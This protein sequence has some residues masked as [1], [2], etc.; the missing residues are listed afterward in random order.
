MKLSRKIISL[1]LFAF[2]LSVLLMTAISKTFLINH[3]VKLEVNNAHSGVSRIV[4]YI[5]SDISEMD[6]LA[7]AYGQWNDT[8]NFVKSYNSKYLNDNFSNINSFNKL[9]TNFIIISDLNGKILF[10]K[11][12]NCTNEQQLSDY[13]ISALTMRLSAIKKYNN[14]NSISGIYMTYTGPLMLVCQPISDSNDST[15]ENG[16]FILAKY[17]DKSEVDLISSVI[18][19]NFTIHNYVAADY[20]NTVADSSESVYIDNRNPDTISGYGIVN[21]IFDSP[22]LSVE[23][24]LPKDILI[25]ADSNMH[26]LIIIMAAI[27]ILFVL[28]VLKFVD[29][30]VLKRISKIKN[31]INVMNYT[32]DLSLRLE[33]N[34]NDEISELSHKF[35]KMIDQ[36]Q[37]SNENL[38]KSER[39]YYSLF[40]NMMSC[41][42]YGKVILNEADQFSDFIILEV[43]N[44]WAYIFD[45]TKDDLINKPGMQILPNELKSHPKLAEMITDV[46]LNGNTSIADVF[47]FERYGT[48]FH[49]TMYSTEKYHFVMMLTDI[50]DKQNAEKKIMN[51]AY[52]DELTDLPNRKKLLEEIQ[53]V[54]E[55]SSEKSEKFALLFIDLDNFKGIN[56]SL[57]HE[58]GDFVLEKT[59]LRLKQLVDDSITVGR[60]GGDEFIIILRHINHISQAEA[61]ANKLYSLIKPV[62]NYKGSELYIGASIGISIYPEDGLTLSQLLRNAD[63]AM[64]AAKRNGGYC[65]ELYS[66]GMND[67][68]LTELIMEGNLRKALQ[69]NEIIVYYQPIV[70]LKTMKTIGAEALTRWKQNDILVPPSQ[71]IPLAKNIGVIVDIDNWVLRTACV[72]CKAWQNNIISGEFHISVNTSYKQIKEPNFIKTVVMAYEDAGLDSKYLK[73]EITE[74]EAM[75]DVELIIDV[76]KKLNARGV[77]ADLDDFG[78]GYSSLSYVNRLPINILKIDRSLINSIDKNPRSVEIVRTIMV[79]CHSLGIRVLAEGVER[80]SQLELLRQFDCDLIQGFII[81]KPVPAEIFEKEFITKTMGW[82]I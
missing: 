20:K 45:M 2:V 41:F 74:D 73:L 62:I 43:N 70:D 55:E 26:F 68:A 54:L 78:T 8:Y 82:N 49:L 24:S 58:V 65:Y 37:S 11:T 66:R 48:W 75:E 6:A 56:D 52:V 3:F 59:A 12:S 23:L 4:K 77:S 7:T 35:N 72:Q 69:N 80:E 81:S 31:T 44:S 61:L 30:I 21:D 13:D 9:N 15:P 16:M 22:A 17:L 36:I 47:Y 14:K 10:K 64:Y 28:I 25:Q 39:K 5:E 76:L 40:S 18:G 29:I 34:N 46:A 57:G 19:M 71:F 60:L 67:Y 1:I 63:T 51:I 27:F 50:T 53:R 32:N 38:L 33:D 79:M 42:M